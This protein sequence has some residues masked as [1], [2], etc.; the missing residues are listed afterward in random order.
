MGRGCRAQPAGALAPPSSRCPG[1]RRQLGSAQGQQ[2]LAAPGIGRNLE[3]DA[4]TAQPEERAAPTRPA[5]GVQPQLQQWAAG[6]PGRRRGGA[7]GGSWGLA[8]GAR[9]EEN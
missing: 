4:R 2:E 8:N 7:A 5:L 3:R 9:E 6:T 1:V